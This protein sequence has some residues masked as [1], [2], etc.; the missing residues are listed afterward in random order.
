MNRLKPRPIPLFF[1]K[2]R[3][4]HSSSLQVKTILDAML[5]IV[6]HKTEWSYFYM[7]AVFPLRGPLSIA[8][9]SLLHVLPCTMA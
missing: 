6:H 5:Y 3:Q 9:H 7:S 1:L 2:D 4:S 8:L